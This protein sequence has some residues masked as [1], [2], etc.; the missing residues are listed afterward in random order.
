M[1]LWSQHEFKLKRAARGCHLVT[2]QV[3]PSALMLWVRTAT[4]MHNNV[5][6]YTG[7][8]SCWAWSVVKHWTAR[9]GAETDI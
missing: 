6:T 1:A 2:E 8:L 4:L 3:Q 5:T 9:A 7:F